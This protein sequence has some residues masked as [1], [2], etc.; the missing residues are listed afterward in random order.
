M[1]ATGTR[2]FTDIHRLLLDGIDPG[3]RGVA[4]YG[5]GEVTDAREEVRHG[6][7]L[8]DQTGNPSP[9]GKVSLGEHS[10]GHVEDEPASVLLVVCLCIGVAS[11]IGHAG[12]AELSRNSPGEADSPHV[13]EAIEDGISYLFR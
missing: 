1:R 2:P 8:P 13:G 9:L 6:L 3:G 5:D 7:A 12:F 10:L 4:G 11:E